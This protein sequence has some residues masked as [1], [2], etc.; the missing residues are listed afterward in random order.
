MSQNGGGAAPVATGATPAPPTP[1][2][3]L[4]GWRDTVADSLPPAVATFVNAN[5]SDF[6]PASYF[7][8]ADV[9]DMDSDDAVT[10]FRDCSKTMSA[11]SEFDGQLPPLPD[12]GTE[13]M[14]FKWRSRPHFA[15]SICYAALDVCNAVKHADTVQ[16]MKTGAAKKAFADAAGV[17][18]AVLVNN[19]L[20]ADLHLNCG[21]HA[22]KV[23]LPS[24]ATVSGQMNAQSV[25]RHSLYQAEVDQLAQLIQLTADAINSVVPTARIVSEMKTAMDGLEKNQHLIL[26]ILYR[27]PPVHGNAQGGR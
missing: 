1:P 26:Q 24:S 23:A 13:W 20:D 6:L 5:G 8:A 3:R 2:V 12:A 11:F 25:S 15:C 17:L 10:R 18:D 9:A 19:G 16:L 14:P 4:L 7:C 22:Q 21:M 27:L